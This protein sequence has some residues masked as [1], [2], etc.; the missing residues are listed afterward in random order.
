M[1]TISKILKNRVLLI[2]G[3]SS[4]NS[5]MKR[6]L[7]MLTYAL[8]AYAMLIIFL[9]VFQRSYLYFPDKKQ[10]P[11]IILMNLISRKLDIPLMMG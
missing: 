4:I 11:I 10:F 1:K 2:F 7:T 3:N 5:K 8:I 6:M 9:F